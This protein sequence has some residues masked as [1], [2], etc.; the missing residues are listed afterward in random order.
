MS[1]VRNKISMFLLLL[2]VSLTAT[3]EDSPM[4]QGCRRG[5]PRT[6]TRGI[7]EER[8]PGGD[9]Y[10]GDLHQLVVMVAFEGR[11]FKGSETATLELWDKIFNQKNFKEGN[12]YGSV[13]DYFCDQSYDQFR[14]VFDLVYLKVGNP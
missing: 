1:D 8:L 10:K 4:R 12:F 3:A 2:L 6:I 5:T 13:H 11:D 7:A 14:P 9:F